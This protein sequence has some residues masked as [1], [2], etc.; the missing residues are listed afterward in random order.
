MIGLEKHTTKSEK[1]NLKL[2]TVNFQ[3][4]SEN[5]RG[6]LNKVQI[7][8]SEKL[9]MLGAPIFSSDIKDSLSPNTPS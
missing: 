8:F 3:K 7:P 5:I 9:I 6:I 2:D 1:A 4:A